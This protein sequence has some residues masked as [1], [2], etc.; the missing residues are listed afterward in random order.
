MFSVA[1]PLKLKRR[2]GGSG[3]CRPTGS[4]K[5][6]LLP[7][8]LLTAVLTKE[9]VPIITADTYR[10]AAQS[11]RTFADIVKVAAGGF[12]SEEIPA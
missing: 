3:V 10:I 5:P 6:L 12:S 8:W 7:N 1:G 2:A 9:S 4:G 11:I